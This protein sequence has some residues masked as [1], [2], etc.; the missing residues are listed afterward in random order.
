MGVFKQ[1]IEFNI[2]NG[3]VTVP[4]NVKASSHLPK[5]TDSPTSEKQVVK[6]PAV[7]TADSLNSSQRATCK[8][9]N[10]NYINL[11]KLVVREKIRYCHC[12]F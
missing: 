8:S 1:T 6:L 5:I 12:K 10:I 2:C 7:R 11:L 9:S 3:I 4:L